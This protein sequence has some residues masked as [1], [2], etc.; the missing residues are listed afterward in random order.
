M[1]SDAN[2]QMSPNK[3]IPLLSQTETHYIMNFVC[4]Q[5]TS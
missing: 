4:F 2:K 5:E 1:K 3:V